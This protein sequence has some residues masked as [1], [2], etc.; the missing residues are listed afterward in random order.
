M[1]LEFA[2]ESASLEAVQFGLNFK[3]LLWIFNE[4]YLNLW[5]DVFLNGTPSKNECLFSIYFNLY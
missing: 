5:N 2:K 3:G 4:F 1:V